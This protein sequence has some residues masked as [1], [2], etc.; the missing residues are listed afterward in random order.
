MVTSIEQHLEYIGD[1]INYMDNNH[2]AT[3]DASQVAEDQWV[4]HVNEVASATLVNS[5]ST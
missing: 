2:L 4:T 3:I 1:I 5:C